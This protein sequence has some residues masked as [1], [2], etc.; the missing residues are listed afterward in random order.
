MQPDPYGQP[1]QVIIDP[2]TG[3]PANVIM[4]QPK[5]GAPKVIGIFI[6]I[7]AVLNGIGSIF[8]IGDAIAIGGLFLVIHMIGILASVG[9]GIGGGMMVQYQKRGVHLTLAMVVLGLILGVASVTMLDDL[10]ESEN[11][12]LSA[13]PGIAELNNG[14]NAGIGLVAIVICNGMC[15]L[16]VAIPLMISN[17]GLDESKLIG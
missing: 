8:G 7:W 1:Q 4:I 16:I 2:I 12:E 3:M 17:N 9:L 13:E 11:E 6:I 14:L 5:S 15:G 10:F